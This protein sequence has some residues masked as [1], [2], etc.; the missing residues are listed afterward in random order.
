VVHGA[1]GIDELSPAG[2]N[3]VCEV[4]GGRV[5]KREIDPLE[6]GIERCDPA[7]LRGG[8]PEE[9]AARTREIFEGADGGARSA[10]LLNAAGAIA[11]AGHARN[12]REGLG[13]AREAI[14]SGA[15]AR[16]LE[17]LIAFTRAEVAA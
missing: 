17:E 11:A 13:H 2:P 10:V 8:S 12:L 4:V 9:N 3:L 1:G 7:E 5:R 16:R 6:L 14:D 15:A